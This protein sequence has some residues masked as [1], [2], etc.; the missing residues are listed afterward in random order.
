LTPRAGSGGTDST[1]PPGE[2][3]DQIFERLGLAAET[4]AVRRRTVADLAYG[5]RL[6]LAAL[7]VLREAGFLPHDVSKAG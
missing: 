5:G 2:T 7:R 6:P 3:L 4:D 1:A